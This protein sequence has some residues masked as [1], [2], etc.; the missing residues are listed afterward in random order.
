[1]TFREYVT[2][3]VGRFG[4]PQSEIDFMLIE[5]EINP[6]ADVVTSEDKRNAKLSVYYQMPIILSGLQNV[7]EGGYSVSWNID[8]IKT[9]YSILCGQLGLEDDLNGIPR[10][11]NKS[12]LW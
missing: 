6:A 5:Q 8:G 12:N 2:A 11:R 9:W 7:S 3:M 4:V 1:M 10:V